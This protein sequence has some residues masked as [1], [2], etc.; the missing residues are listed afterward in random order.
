M[1]SVLDMS[2]GKSP[3]ILGDGGER[4][5]NI[6]MCPLERS[7]R[8]DTWVEDIFFNW[9]SKTIAIFQHQPAEPVSET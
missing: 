6:R 1:T 8:Q 7:R 4:K 5:K 3:Q 2:N 9:T